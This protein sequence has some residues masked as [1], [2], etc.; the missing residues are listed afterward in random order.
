[1]PDRDPDLVHGVPPLVV[2][3]TTTLGNKTGTWKAIR[4]VHQDRVAPCNAGCPV[5][6]DIEGYMNL[7]RLGLVDEAIDLL[8]AENP[9]PATTGRVC[10]HPCEDTCNRA[11]FDEAV[12]VHAVERMLGDL[13][14]ERPLPSPPAERRPGRIAV[15]GSGPAGLSCAYHLAR[16]GYG[17]TVYEEDLQPGGMLRA[18]IPAYRL[19]RHVLDR[20]LARIQ[21]L[22]VEFHCGS[23]V[24]TAAAGW[25][26]LDAYD[27]VFLAT[28]AHVSRAA[29]FDG[30]RLRGVRS[31]LAFLR[32]VNAGGRPPVGARVVVVGGGNTAIDCARSAVRLGAEALVLYRRSREEMPAF[33]AEVAEAEQ[34]G[35]CFEFLAAPLAAHAPEGVLAGLTCTR[36]RLG[37]PDA[38]GRRRPVAIPGEEFFL[39]A[40]GILLAVGEQPDPEGLPPGLDPGDGQVPVDF[41]GRS[42]REG[43]YAGGDLV[44]QPRTV[45]HAIGSGKR[46][47]IAIDRQLRE[48]PEEAPGSGDPAS[49]RLGGSG[50]VSMT[51][52]R[53]DDPVERVNEVNEVVG[54]DRI[55]T[56]CMQHA[57]RH[58]EP[59]AGPA[60]RRGGFEEVNRGLPPA[61][62]LA[63]AGR[64]FNCGVCN[65]CELCR[66]YCPDAAITKR[67]GAHGF[68]IAY[69]YCKGCGLCSAECPRGAISMTR[70]G[71]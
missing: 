8:L 48:A 50:N 35:V 7:L 1:V 11:R 34:E 68:V 36:M 64:C 43:M 66:I 31:G 49:L 65:E 27:A 37:D 14:L 69:D 26:T 5:G 3:H 13:A 53:K 51:R 58:E 57:A 12:S 33:A 62:A 45:A 2:S 47:A 71:L 25:E 55:N 39:P 44:A 63:E 42:S 20:E 56:A 9:L 17:V 29:G 24:G 40:D 60:E 15:V 54:P 38:S 30:E 28:G 19:P 22:G 18:G 41:M 67:P 21:A 59:L 52:W 16:L 70:E 46:V 6:I 23:K 61:A 4:P 10:P 32:E